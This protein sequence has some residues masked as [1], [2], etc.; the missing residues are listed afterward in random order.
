MCIS[1]CVADLLNGVKDVDVVFD[2]FFSELLT[3]DAVFC[4]CSNCCFVNFF[5]L[6]VSLL[7]CLR[8]WSQLIEISDTSLVKL[9]LYKNLRL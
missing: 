9:F 4:D 3:W 8:L 6:R 2:F 7:S 1:D 5:I